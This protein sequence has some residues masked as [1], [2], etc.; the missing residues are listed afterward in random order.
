MT[1]AKSLLKIKDR[2]KK[3]KKVNSKQIGVKA[4]KV[5]VYLQSSSEDSC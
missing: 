1:V 3:K 5:G 4:K 2:K